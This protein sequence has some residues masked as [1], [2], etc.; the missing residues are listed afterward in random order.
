MMALALLIFKYY[1]FTRPVQ[2]ISHK[3]HYSTCIC[4]MCNEMERLGVDEHM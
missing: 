2:V 1:C 4:F 3:S